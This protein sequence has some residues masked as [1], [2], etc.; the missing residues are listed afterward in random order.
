ME[1]RADPFSLK[2][3]EKDILLTRQLARLTEYHRAHCTEYNRMLAA[4]GQNGTDILHYR[5]LPFLPVTLFKHLALSSIAPEREDCKVMTSSG[6]SGQRRSQVV[7]DAE[8]RLR[9]QQA[10]ASIGSSFLGERRMPMLILDAP[11]TLRGSSRSSARGAGILG[12]ALFSSRRVFALK[13]DLSLDQPAILEFL[14]QYGGEPF[15]IFGFTWL[16][17]RYF[18]Q[19]L[20]R[21]SLHL[22]CENGILIHGGGWKTLQQEAVSKTVFQHRLRQCCGVRRVINYYG[23]AEQAGSIFLECE[24]GHLHAS[25]Y[26]GI[27]IRRPEDFSLCDVGETGLIQVLSIV[28]KSYPGHNLLTEDEGRLLGEDDCPC[29]RKGAYFEVI[30]R[31]KYAELRGCSDIYASEFGRTVPFHPGQ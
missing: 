20:E 4:L 3:E 22:P 15:L 19:E 12:F 16:I 9:Q 21:K 27:L 6:T 14:E 18:C 1:L 23:M 5:D 10:L 2:K 8:T 17:W 24:C 28:P 26:S 29:G 11:S 7:L 13:E 30:G 31:A 25:D